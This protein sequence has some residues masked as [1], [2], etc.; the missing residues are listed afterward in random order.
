MCRQAAHDRAHAGTD[1]R[2]GTVHNEPIAIPGVIVALDDILPRGKRV[3]RQRARRR[4]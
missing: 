4:A 1:V 3:P 2:Y